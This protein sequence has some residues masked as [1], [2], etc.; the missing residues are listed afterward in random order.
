M[1]NGAQ[2]S[3]IIFLLLFLSITGYVIYHWLNASEYLPVKDMRVENDVI[4]KHP[5]IY[6]FIDPETSLV[7]FKDGSGKTLIPPQ[8]E[9]A[10]DFNVYGIT[11]I[12]EEKSKSWYKINTSGK[13]LVK[14]YFFDNGPDYYVSGFSRFESEGK[15]GF[16]N[17]KSEII[18]PA[19]FDWATPFFFSMPISVVCVGCRPEKYGHEDDHGCDHSEMKGGKWGVV[20]KNNVLVIPLEYTGYAIEKDNTVIMLKGLKK[21]QLFSSNKQNFKLIRVSQ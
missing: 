21:Y 3:K 5:S 17:E 18:I 16:V 20:S 14:S 15:I 11:D 10:F 9:N 13:R 19:R 2:S 4:E 12:F 6:K 7:G 1:W 8:Y